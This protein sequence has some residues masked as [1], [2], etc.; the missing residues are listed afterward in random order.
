MAADGKGLVGHAGAV[1]M[2]RLADRVGLTRGLAGV[3][4]SSTSAGWRERAGVLVQLAVVMVLGARSLLEAEQLQLH[5]Q[6]LFG[7]VASDSTMRRLLAGVD[8]KTLM[9]V[10]KV[11]RRVRRHVW[12]LLH[13]RPGSFPWLTVAG[14]RLKGWIVVDLDA[15]VITSASRKEGAAAT[16]KGTFGFHPLGG[17][18]ANT[19]E[20]LAMELRAG[21]AGANTVD[22]HVR[23]LAAALDQIP[24]SSQSKILV[25]V[26][27]AGATHGLLEHLEALNTKRRTVRYTVGWKITP[28]DEAAIAKLPESAWETSLKQDGDLQAGYQVAELTCLNTRDGWPEG[29]RLIVRRVRPSRRHMKKLTAFE[30][31]TGWRY[32]VTAT[33]IRHMWGIAG[34]HQIQFLDALHRD[35]AEVEDRVRTN[36]AMGLANLPSQSWQINEAWMLAAN[37][38]A[39][40][41]TWLRLLTL[42][43]QDGLEGAEPETMR[44]R[45]YHLPARLA[46]HARRRILR[47]ERT[48]PWAMAFTTSWNR[49]TRLP[50]AT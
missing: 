31:R 49:L 38:A 47:I 18:C 32:S 16:F 45:I 5:H 36:K 6:G 44:L 10:A 1:L 11:R 8:G 13:L 26:D 21:N 22:D 41:D 15:T 19:G 42:H 46:S 33:N 9:K 39:D 29:M 14:R 34:S 30:Q 12:M 23:V 43:D 50:V 7:A 2:R 4:P 3:L 40:L 27:G 24:H 35:H 28:E 20:C 25:R 37:L 17:W 48:W